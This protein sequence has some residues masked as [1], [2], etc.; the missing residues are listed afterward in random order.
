MD[1]AD[2]K[3]NPKL[4]IAVHLISREI[5]LWFLMLYSTRMLDVNDITPDFIPIF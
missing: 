4:G 2:D 5:Y 1:T 3:R